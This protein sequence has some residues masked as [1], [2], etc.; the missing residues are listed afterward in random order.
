MEEDIKT[1]NLEYLDLLLEDLD[2]LLRDGDLS[3][4]DLLD[5]DLLRLKFCNII[6]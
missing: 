4:R 3:W 5:G 6:P 2:L 1:L